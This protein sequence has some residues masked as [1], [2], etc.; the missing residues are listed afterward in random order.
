M[1]GYNST[2]P[3]PL[4]YVRK[5]EIKITRPGVKA[6]TTAIPTPCRGRAKDK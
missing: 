4:K 3:D 5:I 6:E 1:L 2:N